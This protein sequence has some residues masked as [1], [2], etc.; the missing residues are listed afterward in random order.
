METMFDKSFT[1]V[2]DDAQL[3]IHKSQV[4]KNL[5]FKDRIVIYSGLAFDNYL[6]A[7]K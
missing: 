7:Y 1:K 3:E 6:T 4:G 5:G 2:N